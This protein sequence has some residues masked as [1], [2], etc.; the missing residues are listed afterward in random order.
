M[1]SNN[2]NQEKGMKRLSHLRQIELE[3][4]KIWKENHVFE[5]N[6]EE[7][8]QNNN[9]FEEKNSKKFLITFPYPYMNGRLHLGHAFSLSKCEFQSRYQRLIGKN[10]LFPFGF[11][12]TGMPIAAA[13]KRVQNEF[14]EDPDVIKHIKEH[15]V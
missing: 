13:A 11:H 3:R 4:Q 10:V 5:A 2:N 9:N 7:N 15:K 6:A 8:W 12:C 1:Q 14:K